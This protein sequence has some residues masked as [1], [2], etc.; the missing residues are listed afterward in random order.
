MTT[1]ATAE[2]YEATAL[3]HRKRFGQYMSPQHICGEVDTILGKFVKT[4][5]SNI[6][7]PSC[8]T[9]ALLELA[10]R[11]F[12][13]AAITG[14]EIDPKI[15]QRT[16]V[17]F[18]NCQMHNTDYMHYASKEKYQLILCNPPYYTVTRAEWKKKYPEVIFPK[19]RI[20][21]YQGIIQKAIDS[22]SDDG[23]AVFLLPRRFQCEKSKDITRKYLVDKAQLI[24]ISLT[25]HT[26]QDA[27]DKFVWVVMAGKNYNTSKMQLPRVVNI[28]ALM[29]IHAEHNYM[30]QQ[31]QHSTLA[32]LNVEVSSGSDT[33][34]LNGPFLLVSKFLGT[35]K[36]LGGKTILV[37][38][39]T[40]HATKG[41]YIV[42]GSL[43]MLQTIQESLDSA[44]TREFLDKYLCW[45]T[46]HNWEMKHMIPIY[47]V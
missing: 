16:E 33:K 46:F 14:V 18:P 47:G 5:P 7:E 31:Q 10:E 20:N 29:L 23:I 44:M 17:R 3:K 21:M 6:L 27:G 28:N 8:G 19:G 30:Q 45:P 26:F 15:F 1:R 12:P 41:K 34:K 40:E 37:G 9:G 42:K 24:Y 4:P 43:E 11:H 32:E 13:K 39:K 36:S 25:Q 22:L 38:D 2:Y 35:G